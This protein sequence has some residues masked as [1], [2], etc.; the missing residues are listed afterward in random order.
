MKAVLQNITKFVSL[1][2]K[3]FFLIVSYCRTV[4]RNVCSEKP[5]TPR[6]R[7]FLLHQ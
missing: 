2:A 5:G 7:N 4:T 6:I 1:I 3:H